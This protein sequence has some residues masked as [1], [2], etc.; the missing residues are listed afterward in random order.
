MAQCSSATLLSLSLSLSVFRNLK[1]LHYKQWS[2]TNIAK[3]P[4]PISFIFK[5][6]FISFLHYSSLSLSLSKPHFLS[7]SLFFFFQNFHHPLLQK[8][9]TKK[10]LWMNL[11]SLSL[12]R[13]SS[14]E[15]VACSLNWLQN[16]PSFRRRRRRIRSE[17]EKGKGRGG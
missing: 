1:T 6:H 7:P 16:L 15:W 17:K 4:N 2:Y 11:M 8:K 3:H 5:T 12:I 9:K 14:G 10:M 13:C